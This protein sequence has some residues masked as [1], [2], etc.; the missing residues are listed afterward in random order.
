MANLV[1][2]EP[3]PHETPLIALYRGQWRILERRTET[4]NW[5]ETFKEFDYWDDPNN[6]GQEIDDHY[7][8][9]WMHLPPIPNHKILLRNEGANNAFNGLDGV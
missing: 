7:V 5:E 3:I 8:T 2:N 6:E 9:H 1:S 4:P